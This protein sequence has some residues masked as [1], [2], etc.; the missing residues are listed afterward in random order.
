MFWTNWWS[1]IWA[2]GIWRWCFRVKRSVIRN[3]SRQD[4]KNAKNTKELFLAGLAAWRETGPFSRLPTVTA[5]CC[6]ALAVLASGCGEKKRRTP[7]VAPAPPAVVGA[8]EEGIASWY[9]NPYHGRR[10]SNRE[11]YDMEKMTAAH[12]TLPFGTRVEVQ[13]LDNGRD[14]EVRINDR[15]PFVEGRIIDLSRAASR[16]IQML[17]PGTARV[18]VKVVGLPDQE[19]P[20]GFY[21]VQIAAFLDRAKAQRLRETMARDYG[22]AELQEYDSPK[23]RFHRVMVGKQG[24]LAGAEELRRKL[25]GKGYAG[26]VVRMDPAL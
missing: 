14:T 7:V 10:T 13:N 17:G 11:I 18:R 16:R 25:R 8:T 20:G 23:G 22:A 21:T 6:L 1:G 26:F 4:A 2:I 19:P 15:G 9:G 3:L 5:R 12:R 24:D